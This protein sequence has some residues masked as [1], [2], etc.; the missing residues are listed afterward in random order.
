VAYTEVVEQYDRDLTPSEERLYQE[1]IYNKQALAF[2][3]AAEVAARV[4]VHESTVVRLA[5]KLGYKGYRDLRASLKKEL[6]EKENAVARMR[7]RV[8]RPH[9]LATLV[10]DEIQALNELSIS[11][12]Q[13]QIDSAAKA[14]ISARQVYLYGWGHASALVEYLDRRLR[15]SKKDTVDLRKEGRDLAEN[16]LTFGSEDVLIAFA[17]HV[18]PP[19]LETLFRFSH[20]AGGTSILISDNLGPLIRPKPDILI[21]ARHSAK[22]EL[23]ALSVPLTITNAL[24]LSIAEFDEGRTFEGLEYLEGLLKRF[25][26]YP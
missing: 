25:D 14:I 26:R 2:M 5:Q 22:H 11:V 10:A 1:F 16:L 23:L 19:S 6:I 7:S 8:S 18:R 20:S 9:E 21:A 3:T 15:R 17:F 4:G 24:V 13:E 12:L